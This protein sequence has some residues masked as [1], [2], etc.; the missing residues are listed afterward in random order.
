MISTAKIEV[1]QAQIDVAIQYTG[2]AASLFD[3][4]LM[5]G[6]SITDD[7]P[8]GTVLLLPPVSDSKV[9]QYYTDGNYKTIT[10]LPVDELISG[11]GVEFWNI[12]YDFV[13]N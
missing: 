5:N 2:D 12:Q 4:A 6:L 11:E 7:V 13:V 9:L 8:P 1:N 3:I 10:I